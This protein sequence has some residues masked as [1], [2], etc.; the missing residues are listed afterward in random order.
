M[1]VRDQLDAP[2]ADYGYDLNGN[3]T[4]VVEPGRVLD[5]NVPRRGSQRANQAGRIARGLA[6]VNLRK[7]A[8]LLGTGV[9]PAAGY[10]IRFALAAGWIAQPGL[11]L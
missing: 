3:R 11:K 5:L 9:T 7:A 4:H 8:T 2:V 1:S 10:V 6:A